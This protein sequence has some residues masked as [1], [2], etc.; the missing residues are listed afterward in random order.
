MRGSRRQEECPE[1]GRAVLKEQEGA[2]KNFYPGRRGKT[3]RKLDLSFRK[4]LLVR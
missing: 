3:L 4:P 1:A 2:M